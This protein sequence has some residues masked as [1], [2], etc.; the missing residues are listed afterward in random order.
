MDERQ[1]RRSEISRFNHVDTSAG[2]H[3]HDKRMVS[4]T[5]P[6]GITTELTSESNW[7][8]VSMR[9]A[10]PPQIHHWMD[11]NMRR[12]RAP[13]STFCA[14]TYFPRVHSRRVEAGRI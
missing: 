2:V 10:W 9:R 6:G 4:D 3:N 11:L 13:A 12:C 5:V 14:T 8:L 7:T 1:C